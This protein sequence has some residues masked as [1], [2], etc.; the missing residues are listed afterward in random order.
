MDNLESIH[1]NK[2]TPSVNTK[3][4]IW[5]VWIEIQTQKEAYS[6]IACFSTDLGGSG[7]SD[8]VRAQHI[9]VIGF[10]SCHKKWANVAQGHEAG[11]TFLE[12]IGDYF[13]EDWNY[14]P[15]EPPL[16]FS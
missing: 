5:S 4:L 3:E 14:H 1:R 10:S 8:L 15:D 12:T 9:N 11:P 13:M 2:L 16:S 6:L 7:R